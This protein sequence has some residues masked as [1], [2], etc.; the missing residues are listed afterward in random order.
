MS[1]ETTDHRKLGYLG[2]PWEEDFGYAQAV[3]I[4][5]SI[6]VSGQL[7]HDEAGAIVAPAPLDKNGKPQGF[8]CM[9]RQMQTTYD[10]AKK[11]L[12]QFGAAL[13]NVV[14][15]TLYVLDVDAAFA[16]AGR[17]RRAAYGRQKPAC[18]SNL[19]GISRLAFPTQLIEITFRAEIGLPETFTAR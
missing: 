9:E 11:I 2:L 17:V 4:G 16:V 10:N 19:I 8:E 6:F 14:E 3:Q 12:A 13:D 15:E 5:T 1:A 7:S 18:A